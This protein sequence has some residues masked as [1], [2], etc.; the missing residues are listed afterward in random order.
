MFICHNA[1]LFLLIDCVSRPLYWIILEIYANN[2]H[3]FTL[4]VIND[5]IGCHKTFYSNHCQSLMNKKSSLIIEKWSFSDDFFR[6]FV[7]I[8]SFY[9]NEKEKI[10][11]EFNK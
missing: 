5:V 3:Y 1:T 2:N 9:L 4:Y 6:Y 10:I 8:T 7:P 11:T